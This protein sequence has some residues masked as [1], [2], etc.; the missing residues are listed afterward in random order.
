MAGL[1]LDWSRHV[2][3]APGSD[4]WPLTWSADGHQYTTFGDGGGF[5][6][7]NEEG[8]ASLG[9]S[10]IVGPH[11]SF[12]GENLWGGAGADSEATFEG[13]SYGIL[14]LGDSLFLWVGPG[15]G[16]ESY[17]EARLALSTDAGRTW[18]RA[19]WAFE[20]STDLAMPTFL[21]YGQDH[22]NAAD[23]FVYTYFVRRTDR[24][25]TLAVH[26]PGM[27]DLARAPRGRLLERGAWEFFRGT[28]GAPAWTADP[29]ARRPA[30]EDANGVG[31]CVSGV[32]LSGPDRVLLA[33]EHGES[34]RGRLGLFEAVDPWGPWSTVTYED[35]WGPPHVPARSFFW[36]F[37]PKWSHG[38][39]FV[40]VFTGIEELDSWNS[41]PGSFVRPAAAPGPDA[42]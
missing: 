38:D 30:F 20:E 40:L 24:G 22:A 16:T 31:W 2:Q 33:T 23:D 27:I 37:S 13:K 26:R 7:T 39:T 12:R 6:G 25:K 32:H 11:D 36:T 29:A 1:S 34:F 10:S 19:P 42:R 17:A 15:S 21:Q 18:E 5:G 28:A 4:N 9:V 3:R 35:S 41:V 14:A 8:R